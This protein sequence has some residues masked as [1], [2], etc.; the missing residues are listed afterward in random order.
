MLHATMKGVDNLA[1]IDS[2]MAYKTM[3]HGAYT[4]IDS[5]LVPEGTRSRFFLHIYCKLDLEFLHT[6]AHIHMHVVIVY[7]YKTIITVLIASVQ[8]ITVVPV[9]P[10]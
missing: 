10:M 1:H 7:E 4:A 8:Q 2:Y 3:A 5:C 6:P 9:L